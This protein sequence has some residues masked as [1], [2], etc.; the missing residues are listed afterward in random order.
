[1]TDDG[2]LARRVARLEAREE[3]RALLMAYRRALDAKDFHAYAALFGSDGVFTAGDVVAT[4]PDEI[5]AMCQSMVPEFLA[6]VAG[7]DLHLM[8]NVEIEADGDDTARARSTWVYVVRGEGDVPQLSKLGH[9]KDDLVREDGRWRFARRH[10]P[11]RDPRAMS[12]RSRSGS[13]KPSPSGPWLRGSAGP[14][15]STGGES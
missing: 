6:A 1:M 4:G 13:M 11:G 8:C 10:A 3:I 7:D 5:R 14:R 12:R 15:R 9:Y 2:D